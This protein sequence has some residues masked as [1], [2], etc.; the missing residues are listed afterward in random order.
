MNRTAVAQLLEV[1]SEDDVRR[2][3]AAARATGRKLSIAGRRH[4]MGGQTL[5]PGHVVLDM[6]RLRAMSLDAAT[7]I[8]TVG[9]GASWSDVQR[10]LDARGRAVL[11][12][13]SDNVFSV[14]G[15]LSVNAHGW[16][17]RRPPIASTVESLRVMLAT[18]E[19]QTCSRGENHEL[20]RGVLGGYGL[21][22][23]ILDARLHTTPNVMYRRSA[24]FLPSAEYPKRFQQRVAANPGVGLAYG[25]LSVDGANL[26]TQSALYVYERAPNAP[27]KLPPMSDEGLVD[28]KREI[29]RA[30]ERSDGG[31]RRRWLLETRLGPWL[32]APATRNTVMNS[33][34]HFLWPTDL[35]RRDILHEYFVPQARF[36]GF[37]GALRDSLGKHRQD[38]LNVTVRDLRKDDDAL[39]AYAREDVFAFVLLFSQLPSAD[40]EARM[41]AF[42]RD[43][44]ERTLALGGTF[45]L[46]Y[47]LH[48]TPEQFR[49]AYPMAPEFLEL[50]RRVD[51]EEL[52]QSRFYDHIR[53]H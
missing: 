3:L 47:R 33:D 14:G 29:F 15:T 17:P 42:T 28:V 34:I 44:V 39:L 38:L 32:E 27:A 10:F 7:G 4:S 46:P 11:V 20:F 37:L 35:S 23:V 40:G 36:E 19:V 26:L 48:Y 30:S 43:L 9:A 2:A 49:R 25:R 31:K 53:T 24:S 51:P 50:K 45:Y 21:M 13:Q 16:Q 18:G 5:G 1:R 12:M 52:F 6:S 22:G 8:L 41:Q